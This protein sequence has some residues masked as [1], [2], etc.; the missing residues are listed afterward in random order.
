MEGAWAWAK[1]GVEKRRRMRIVYFIDFVLN[2]LV[3]KI[4]KDL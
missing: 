1:M 3:F 4:N 2:I